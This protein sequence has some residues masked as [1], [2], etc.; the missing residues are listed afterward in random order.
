MLRRYQWEPDEG[1]G[2]RTAGGG[3]EGVVFCFGDIVSDAP[4]SSLKH[5][6]EYRKE[7]V[8]DHMHR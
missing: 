8:D 2:V 1:V 5:I 4:S 7:S 3:R 6:L